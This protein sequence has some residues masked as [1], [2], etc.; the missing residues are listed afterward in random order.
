MTLVLLLSLTL[1]ITSSQPPPP[2]P[3]TLPQSFSITFEE[4]LAMNKTPLGSNY[5]NWT[6][7]FPNKR[8]RADHGRGQQN[9]FCQHQN[10]SDSDKTAPC[11]L[12][13]T[14]T[15]DLW[16]DYPEVQ[17]CC[18]LC[19]KDQGC[20]I[21]SPDWITSGSHYINT[22]IISGH[23]CSSYGKPGAVAPQDVWYADDSDLKVRAPCRYHEIAFG[24]M[25]NITF[26]ISSLKIGPQ[27]DNMFTVPSYCKDKC[28]KPYQPPPSSYNGIYL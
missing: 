11:S 3:P 26:D 9:N 15:D 13:F 1:G 21:L 6:Y 22:E 17:K 16:V 10:L 19:G 25:H 8:W 20:T 12:H 18:W 23:T 7:D 5:G 2:P 27:P 14:P 4:N 24:I 28:P